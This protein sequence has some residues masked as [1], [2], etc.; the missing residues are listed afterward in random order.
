MGMLEVTWLAVELREWFAVTR[1]TFPINAGE[2]WR[3]E[4][5]GK[6]DQQQNRGKYPLCDSFFHAHIGDPEINDQHKDNDQQSYKLS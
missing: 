1:S 6:V 2:W 3:N 4:M 5:E